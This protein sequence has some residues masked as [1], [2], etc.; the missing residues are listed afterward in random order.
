MHSG[1][2]PPANIY[3]QVFIVAYWQTNL[4]H[5]LCNNKT[6]ALIFLS[7]HLDFSVFLF[8]LVGTF[9]ETS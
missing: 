2:K 9:F 3:K 6:T 4:T 7:I 8:A 1:C 5:V